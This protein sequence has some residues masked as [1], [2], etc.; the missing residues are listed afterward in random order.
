L[1]EASAPAPVGFA[2]AKYRRRFAVDVVAC[3]VVI[4]VRM[5]GM[6]SV[7]FVDGV[8]VAQD[9]TPASGL[10]AVRNHHLQT[11]LP[12][13]GALEIEA[14]YVNWVSVGI[15]VRRDGALIHQSHPGKRIAYPESARKMV[16][17]GKDPQLPTGYDPGA[18]GRN[19]VPILIDV[20][21]GLLFYVVAKL[22]DLSTAAL[23]GAAA[24]ILLVIV[25][26][27]VKTD[28]IGGL[29]LFG[30]F[31][32]LVSA[33]LALVFQD[34]MAV[35]MRTSIVGTISAI[36]FLGDGL[37]GGNR[38]GKGLARY[39]PYSDIDPGRLAVGMGLVGL[40]MAVLNYGV[41]RVASPSVWLFYTAFVDFVLMMGLIVLVF[42]YARGQ[43]F[44]PREA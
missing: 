5:S 21:L 30:I 42:R 17:N 22:T 37:L 44:P 15:A 9:A 39:L 20:A 23:V 24:G 2:I 32:L 8:A 35:K 16:L 1:N 33:G 26:R 14:G 34:D 36:L 12:G 13:G 27:F 25:Q 10:E 29:A 11:I 19:K 38:L 4:T 7:L 3:E 28:L 18:L 41:A 40:V 31:M 43:M 6:E